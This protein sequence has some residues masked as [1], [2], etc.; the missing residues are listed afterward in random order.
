MAKVESHRFVQRPSRKK[1]VEALAVNFFRLMTYLVILAAAYIFIDIAANGSKA[2]FQSKAPFINIQFLTEKPQTLHVFEPRA[3]Y[4]NMQRLRAQTI[5]LKAKR[6]ALGS[7]DPQ[8]AQDYAQQIERLEGEYQTLDAQRK[9][10]RLKYSD[11][12]YRALAKTPDLAN[13]K[14]DTYAYSGGGIGPAIVG[15]CLLVLGSIAI[16][17]SLGLLCAIYLSEYSRPGKTLQAIRLSVLNLSG[18][19]SIVFGLF[20]FGMFVLF[21]GW[22]VSMIA[23]WFTL[24]IM[25]LPVI[26]AASEESMRAIPRGFREGSLALGATKWTSIRTNVLPYALP[27]I[28]TSSIMGIARV[29]GETAPIMFTAAYALRD[30][31]PWEGLEQP[32]DFFFQGVM[33]LPYHIYVVSSKIPQNE[34]TRDMQYGTAFVFLFIVGFFALSSILL[35]IKV[36]S[37][38]KW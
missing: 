31:L 17:L 28:L 23:G 38:Y 10:E 27:G 14:H 33:A 21:F 8:K 37:K 12:A 26:I 24:A 4:E 22:G 5:A 3:I 20:G 13:Y 15:T 1:T 6:K 19:P 7:S 29:A 16:A 25:A 32:T 11:N 30:Q 18:V 35:R 36:R 9:E 2:V 34:Y